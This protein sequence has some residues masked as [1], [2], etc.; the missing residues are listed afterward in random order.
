M[1]FYFDCKKRLILRMR[2][3]TFGGLTDSM[4]DIVREMKLKNENIDNLL[5]NS[6]CEGIMCHGYGVELSDY[7][8]TKNDVLLYASLVKVGLE[9]EQKGEYPFILAAEHAINSF[10]YELI[11]CAEEWE[12]PILKNGTILLTCKDRRVYVQEIVPLSNIF[13]EYFHERILALAASKKMELTEPSKK[14]LDALMPP[15]ID[16]RSIEISAYLDTEEEVHVLADLV[17]QVIEE[18]PKTYTLNT[19]EQASL[20]I[21]YYRLLM[22]AFDLSYYDAQ[23]KVKKLD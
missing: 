22:Y 2:A 14:L 10:Y 1:A 5:E 8:K 21:L 9:K 11:R 16:D 12:A 18:K 4:I 17:K 23:G 6:T 20:W 3:T 19:L 7:L 15:Y 13:C